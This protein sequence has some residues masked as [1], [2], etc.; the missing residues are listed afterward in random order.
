M[1]TG[2]KS[3]LLR[4]ADP[5]LKGDTAGTELP[6]YVRGTVAKPQFGVEVRKALFGR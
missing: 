4:I 3:F 6:I 1:V 5:L 2:F